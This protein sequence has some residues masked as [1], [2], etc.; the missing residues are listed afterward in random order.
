MTVELDK[1]SEEERNKCAVGSLSPA[2][3]LS[4]ADLLENKARQEAHEA[5]DKC[6]VGI[7]NR[8]FL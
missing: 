3:E 6:V 7:G 5:R 2:Q 8:L 4:A 1:K